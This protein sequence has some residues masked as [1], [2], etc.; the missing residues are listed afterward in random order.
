MI[1]S[2]SFGRAIPVVVAA[3]L[4]SIIGGCAK[5]GMNPVAPENAGVQV[6]ATAIFSGMNSPIALGK[7]SGLDAADSIRI[8]SLAVVVARIRLHSK[9]DSVDVD[10]SG[11]D[12]ER[13]ERDDDSSLTLRGPF[14]VRV[15]DTFSV[16]FASQVVPAGSYD[17]VTF[18]IR[19]LMRGERHEDSDD[20]HHPGWH[21]SD[22]SVAGSSIVI[23]GRA[24]KGG[25]WTPFTLN[26][27]LELTVR[28]KGD[29]V[30]PVAVS[31]INIAFN[32]DLGIWFRDP[33]TGAFLDPTDT[34]SQNREL[35]VR[36]I[37]H[38]LGVARGGCDRDHDGHPDH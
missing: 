5:P 4:L 32:F 7:I 22:S 24:L 30:V 18:R 2:Q 23:W 27:D 21:R 13:G 10:S 26:L 14:I 37:R 34:S 12:H 1:R 15:R 9:I 6:N 28:I 38:A 11:D 19:R 29:F 33:Q 20:R 3:A 8:D 16:D 25:T 31:S 17:G 35:I 36:A